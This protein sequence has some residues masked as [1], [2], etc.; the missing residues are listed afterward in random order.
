MVLCGRKWCGDGDDDETNN[1]NPRKK[2]WR[3]DWSS[4]AIREIR[5]L[6]NART[7][8]T[9]FS[10]SLPKTITLFGSAHEC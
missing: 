3:R 7:H 10:L 1:S 5:G 4:A 6:L 2:D 8:S 9:A